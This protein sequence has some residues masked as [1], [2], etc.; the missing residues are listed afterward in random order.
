M[1]ICV[2]ATQAGQEAATQ[3]LDDPPPLLLPPPL[4]EPA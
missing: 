3:P 1:H 2:P 4:V